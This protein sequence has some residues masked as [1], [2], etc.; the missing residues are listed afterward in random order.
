MKY[1]FCPVPSPSSRNPPSFI[2]C[3]QS[4]KTA[5]MLALC[6]KLREYYS[7]AAVTNDIFTREDCE[8]LNRNAALSTER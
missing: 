2:F 4:G 8:F 1:L 7:I 5:L 6:R 3:C